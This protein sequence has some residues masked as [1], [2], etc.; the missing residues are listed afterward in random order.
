MLNKLEVE[1]KS[2]PFHQLY[3]GSCTQLDTWIDQMMAVSE[4]NVLNILF[5]KFNRK[6]KYVVVQSKYTWVTDQ[7]TY[8][9]SKKHGDWLLIDFEHFFKHNTE[10]LKT[11]CNSTP[12]S[13][14]IPNT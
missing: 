10:L 12:S 5:M 2:F 8:Y 1:S 11:Y 14:I 9:T 7:F 13:N 3:T 6:G 4:E